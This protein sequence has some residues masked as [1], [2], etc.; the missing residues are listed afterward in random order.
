LPGYRMA[1]NKRNED[2]GEELGKTDIN[3]IKAP[4]L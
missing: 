4:A 1:D 2:T 3:T